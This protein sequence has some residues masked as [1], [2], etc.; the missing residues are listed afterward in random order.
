[1][2]FAIFAFGLGAV[3]NT[4]FIQQ[5]TAPKQLRATVASN[6]GIDFKLVYSAEQHVTDKDVRY[7]I[8]VDTNTDDMTEYWKR[9]T[10]MT[11]IGDFIT[12]Q[13]KTA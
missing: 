5:N 13:L 3:T 10:Y 1:M 7:L 12:N 9:I 4:A 8:H 11:K 6:C 2:A